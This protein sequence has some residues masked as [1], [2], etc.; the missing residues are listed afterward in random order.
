MAN[1]DS[2]GKLGLG[3]APVFLTAISTILGAVLFLRFGYAVGSVGF[4]GAIGIIIIGHLVTIPT[5]M[6]IAEIATNQKVEG[7][8]EYFIIS[9]SFGLTIGG[10]IGVALFISQALSVAFYIIAFA[11]A[12]TPVLE[13]VQNTYN[14]GVIDKRFV[15]I[16]TMMLFTL[17][18]LTRGAG[19][20]VKLLYGV[21]A[22]L[23]IALAMFF[24]GSTGYAPPEGTNAFVNT[25]ENPDPFFIV[26]AII[27]PAFTGMTAGV[28]LSGDLKNPGKSIPLGTIGG[29][30]AGMLMYVFIAYKLAISASP[31]MLVE[32]QLIMSQIALWG[33]IIPIG[34]ACATVSSA[35]GSI[36]VAPRTLQA[37]G[38]D[39]IIPVRFANKW[40][41]YGRAGSNEPIN[42]SMVTCLI[43][44]AII[45]LGDINF[46]AQIISM[47]FM[48]T[49]GSL[50]LISFLEHFASNPSYRP[51]FRSR[52]YISLLGAI[53]CILLM[54]QMN[55]PYAIVSIVII[56]LLYFTIGRFK[57]DED[58]LAALFSGVIFQLSRAL[59]V[60]LQKRE[61]EKTTTQW[62]PS[63]VIISD[64]TFDNHD[65]FNLLCWV[66]EKYG[67]GTLIHLIL[68]YL[69]RQTAEEANEAMK[70]LVTMVEATKSNVY[71]DTLVSPSFTTAIAQ[72]VQLPGISGKANN[73]VLFSCS[74]DRRENL[75]DF[76]ATIPLI[77]CQNFDI[78][79]LTTTE[80]S[81]GLSRE[82]HIW[83]NPKDF[84]NENLMILLGYIIK[85]H[86]KWRKARFQINAIYPIGEIKERRAELRERIRSG[87]IPISV[88]NIN[89]IAQKEGVTPK[90]IINEHSK[91]SD[92]TIIG[93][94]S[95]AATKHPETV[96]DGYDELGNILFI[97]ASSE[98]II[99]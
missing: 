5:A 88:K 30:I 32:D 45:S 47:F 85:G 78:G 2:K 4:I 10:T 67:F 83:M 24:L 58:G 11:E 64:K 41:S 33:P 80:R 43:A 91:T 40:L 29:T 98:I 9:R 39:D 1:E 35:I 86:R 20:G 53:M 16:P 25:V 54:F 36:M 61:S 90:Q 13:W 72:A 59:Q 17:L 71:L 63:M 95:R 76:I 97:N 7:G 38:K 27:F 19:A 93:F 12:F 77:K 51:T 79:I 92:L 15:S 55:T 89:I 65:A 18:M 46:V 31:E 26:F 73:M 28:G 37:L 34:L 68:G 8:G 22:V 44:F 75:K 21:V 56:F 94:S 96:F 99:K 42:A 49:Y 70:R 50:C 3:T 87:R 57:E 6:A 74:R 66:S 52:W 60:F 23:F 84:N 81:F 62:R 82:I 48:I 69:S 14:L